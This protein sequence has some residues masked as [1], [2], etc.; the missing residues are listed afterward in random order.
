MKEWKSEGV[1]DITA[2]RFN[3]LTIYQIKNQSIQLFNFSTIQQKI[4]DLTIARLHGLTE[5]WPVTGVYFRETV[6]GKC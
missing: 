6:N 4:N 3:G 2:N 1:I 5:I